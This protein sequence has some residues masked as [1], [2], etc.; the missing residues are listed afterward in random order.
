MARTRTA[1]A[2]RP[3]ARTRTRSVNA[4]GD[5]ITDIGYTAGFYPETAPGHM[6]FAALCAGRSPG[7]ALR[8]RRMLELGF[9]QGFG[10]ALLAA[11]NPDMA[12]EG[13]DISGVHVAHARGLIAEAGLTNLVVSE[14]SFEASATQGG[15]N[16]VDV[17]VLHGVLSWISRASQEAVVSILG[18][19]LR[20]DGLVYVSYNCMPGWAPLA[21]IRHLMREVKRRNPG[22]TEQQ[23]ALALD[24][25]AKL[26]QSN[27]GYFSV[28]PIAAQH[29]GAMLRMDRV[30]L[31]HEYLAEHA[32]M[33]QF[34]DV[35][36]LLSPA[37][38]SY[39]GSATL[40][41]NFDR[42]AAAEGIVPLIGQIGDPIL[43][44][45]VRDFAANRRFR[46]DLFGRRNADPSPDER[47][48]LL[49]GLSFAPAVPRNRMVFTIPGPI[50]ELTLKPELHGA[51]MDVLEREQASFDELLALPA[52]R[53]GGADML[54]DCVALLVDS[55]HVLALA[56]RH[57]MDMRPAQR[58]NRMVVERARGG[59]RY[60]H[61]ASPVARTGVPV[62]EYG[63]LALAAVFDGRAADPLAA[64]RHALSILAASGRR[65]LRENR[66]IDDDGEAVAY[67]A[68]RMTPMLQ[69]QMPVWRR[70]GVL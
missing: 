56:G 22:G 3:F 28:N 12:F 66:P 30:Y 46:R 1:R 8:P 55:G 37:G 67:L 58:F 57:E 5:T 14:T 21:P 24:L 6:G 53:A 26:W 23:L 69:E 49:S 38:L 61:L 25:V 42:Y 60:G 35:A 52:F 32:E 10:L 2:A 48:R 36:A 51:V 41:D 34:S 20:P 44:E 9:G 43:R 16:D 62:D 17:V 29:F 47:R 11:A 15:H 40:L 50:G 54:L 45:T 63:L 18:R 7:L 65:P 68:E 31:A 39:G 19:R 4:T 27:A 13:C 59:R 64:A 70:L 33:P